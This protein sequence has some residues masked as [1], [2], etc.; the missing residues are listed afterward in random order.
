MNTIKLLSIR[1]YIYHGLLT[2]FACIQFVTVVHAEGLEDLYRRALE[3]DPNYLAQ[4]HKRAASD[5]VRAQARSLWLPQVSGNIRGSRIAQDIVRSDNTVFASGDTMFNKTEYSV[6]LRQSVFNYTKM[7][8]MEKADISIKRFATEFNAAEQR[9]IQQLTERYFAVLAANESLGYILTEKQAV[10]EQFDLVEA[11]LDRGLANTV[12]FQDAQARLLQVSAREIELRNALENSK[13]DLKAM[14]GE[15]PASLRVMD[16]TLP[17]TRPMPSDAEA[18]IQSAYEQNPVVIAKRFE[19]EESK[20]DI[21][22][23]R[24]GYFPTLDLTASYNK[25]DTGGSLFGG[26]SEV[27]TGVVM[28]ELNVP[29]FSGGAVTSRFREAVSIN[30]QVREELRAIM[31]ELERNIVRAMN[32]INNSIAK[33]EALNKLV[34]ASQ[35]SVELKRTAYETGLASTIDV[36]DAERNLFFAR[37]EYARAR[38]E[39]VIY[40]IALKHAAGLLDADDVAELDRSILSGSNVLSLY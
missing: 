39:Y 15:L 14:I 4:Y 35:T 38:F 28:L 19:L 24:G 7:I 3:R 36:L 33:V 10:Q 18:W 8:A 26:G 5:Q 31:M 21:E 17:L 13:V 16:N 1:T 25:D 2:I 30:N 34:E 9:L 6:D 20:K 27:D 29:I 40:T 37:S 32:G 11:K 23:Q 12:N 22:Q